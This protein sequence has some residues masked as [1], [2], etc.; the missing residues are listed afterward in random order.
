LKQTEVIRRSGNNIAEK[1]LTDDRDYDD[2]EEIDALEEHENVE[3]AVVPFANA[4]VDPGAVMVVPVDAALAEDAVTA[5]RRPDNFAVG[6]QA[7]RFE[8]VEQFDEVEIWVLLNHSWVAAPHDDT[9]ENCGAEQT[10]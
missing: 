9:E 2:R 10:L 4:I 6:T 7:A 5:P 1:V 3:L 8:R